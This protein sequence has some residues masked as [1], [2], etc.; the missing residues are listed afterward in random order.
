MCKVKSREQLPTTSLL[1]LGGR[2]HS[3]YGIELD[4]LRLK[5]PVDGLVWTPNSKYE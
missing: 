5:A 1:A 2:K 3:S 4:C